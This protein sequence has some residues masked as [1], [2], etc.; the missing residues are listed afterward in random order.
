MAPAEMITV[1]STSLTSTCSLFGAAP[2]ISGRP[3]G[4]PESI[5]SA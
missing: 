5:D 1:M 4:K 3:F 2:P